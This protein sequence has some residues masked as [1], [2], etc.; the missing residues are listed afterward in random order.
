MP[1]VRQQRPT[2]VW[3]Y[4]N[5]CIQIT[6]KLKPRSV[7]LIHGISWADKTTEVNF[8]LLLN[9]SEELSRTSSPVLG[10]GI[11]TPLTPPT[12]GDQSFTATK[13][14]AAFAITAARCLE[15]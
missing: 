5:V 2:S 12:G 11:N 1:V 6:P 3:G 15:I 8:L 13:W 14:I 4:Q 9:R 10:V 7:L